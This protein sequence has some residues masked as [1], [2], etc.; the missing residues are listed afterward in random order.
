MIILFWIIGT[1]K[2]LNIIVERYNYINIFSFI[3]AITFGWI[4]TPI[5]LLEKV[6][7]FLYGIQERI[8]L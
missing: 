3:A 4:F 7:I 8:E 6:L 5:V 2:I 1:L